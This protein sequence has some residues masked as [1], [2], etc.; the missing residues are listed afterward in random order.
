MPGARVWPR[1]FVDEQTVVDVAPMLGHS[2]DR[3]GPQRLHPLMLKSVE[4]RSAVE[5]AI[6]DNTSES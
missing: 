1:F 6:R 5:R 4:Q 3:I 2:V